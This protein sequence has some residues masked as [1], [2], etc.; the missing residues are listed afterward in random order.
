MLNGVA[1]EAT[2]G[3][4]KAGCCCC[5]MQGTQLLQRSA[6]NK[7]NWCNDITVTV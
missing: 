2:N 5:T 4:L 6:A 3:W 7:L 1:L